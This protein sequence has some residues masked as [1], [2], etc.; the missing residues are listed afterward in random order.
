MSV[1]HIRLI[2]E[3]VTVPSPTADAIGEG[4]RQAGIVRPLGINE[5]DSGT[6]YNLQLLFDADGHLFSVVASLGRRSMSADLGGKVMVLDWS[7]ST[8]RWP[9]WSIGMLGTLSSAGTLCTNGRRR[10][11]PLDHVPRLVWWRYLGFEAQW[12]GKPR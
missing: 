9:H 6:V 2:E 11:D 8:V 1:E 4:C 12:N 5:R 3:S 10:A 7:L